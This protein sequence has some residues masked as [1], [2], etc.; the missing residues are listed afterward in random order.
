V[1]SSITEV[2]AL[3][4]TT[5]ALLALGHPQM[6]ILAFT[7]GMAQLDSMFTNAGD[8][9]INIAR[10]I[11][12]KG[13][14]ETKYGPIS[15]IATQLFGYEALDVLDAA[16]RATDISNLLELPTE[17]P[18]LFKKVQSLES[19]NRLMESA[20][21]LKQSPHLPE[22]ACKKQVDVGKATINMLNETHQGIKSLLGK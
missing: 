14:I 12:G 10:A 4:F 2:V 5:G 8:V 21:I 9:G 7:G 6:S 1:G 19:Y 3:G 20:A 16:K 11:Q 18:A 15:G 17:L 22:Y 13:P